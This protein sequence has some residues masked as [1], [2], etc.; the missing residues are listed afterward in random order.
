[1][2]NERSYQVKIPSNQIIKRRIYSMEPYLEL[3]QLI[4][5]LLSNRIQERC[6]CLWPRQKGRMLSGCNS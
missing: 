3:T 1:M 5:A 6:L 2:G 4:K